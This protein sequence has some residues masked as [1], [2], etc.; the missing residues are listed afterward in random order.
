MAILMLDIRA[1]KWEAIARKY[2]PGGQDC[3]CMGCILENGKPVG[4]CIFTG[5]VNE[6]DMTE[7]LF[8]GSNGSDWIQDTTTSTSTTTT[9]NADGLFPEAESDSGWTP[10][11]DEPVLHQV[12]LQDAQRRGDKAKL[13]S[14]GGTSVGI[15]EKGGGELNNLNQTDWAPLP[16]PL[17]I[18]SGAGETVMPSDWCLSHKI[19]DGPG[20]GRDYYI[21]ANGKEIWNEGQK[22]LLLSS[23]E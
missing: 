6:S 7:C 17:V 8:N 10:V 13:R 18:D 1:G 16:K 9:T 22:S 5:N 12:Q 14:T 2:T 19:E 23:L 20:K 4:R 11:T 21:A 3:P 15:L